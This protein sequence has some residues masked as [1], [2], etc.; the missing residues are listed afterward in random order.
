M[1]KLDAVVGDL[2]AE[3][4]NTVKLLETSLDTTVVLTAV[5]RDIRRKTGDSNQ[6]IL[7]PDTSVRP[8]IYM[9]VQ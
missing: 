3:F 4:S 5:I 7:F 1:A 6:C 8:D 2:R 9:S